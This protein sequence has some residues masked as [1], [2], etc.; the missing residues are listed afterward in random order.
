MA[1]NK[2]FTPT[3]GQS[4]PDNNQQVPGEGGNV[5]THLQWLI[6][7]VE[8]LQVDTR[9]LDQRMDGVFGHLADAKNESSVACALSRIEVLIKSNDEKLTALTQ[10]Q[11]ATDGKLSNLT[12]NQGIQTS[13][14]E[15]LPDIEIKLE[16]LSGIEE[17][18]GKLSDIEAKISKLDDI[19]TTLRATKMTLKVCG[20]ILATAGAVAWY[21]LGD[22]L[23]KILAAINAL[24]LK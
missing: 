6:K 4:N 3:S 2:D 21:L 17:K 10:G 22:Y 23:S 18:L 19:D 11:V 8:A 7:S 15:R 16:K 12:I 1:G 20:A 9:R 13:K 14:L 5:H 24:V